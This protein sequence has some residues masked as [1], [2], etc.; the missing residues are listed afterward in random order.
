M[1]AFAALE[2]ERVGLLARVP[3]QFLRYVGVSVAALAA[4]TC[5]YLGLA[6]SGLPPV[7]AGA[8]GYLVGLAAHYIL[9]VALVFDA[10][11]SGKRQRRLV[12]EFVASGLFGLALTTCVISMATGLGLA[13]LAAKVVAVALSFAA[14]YMLRRSV[15]FAAR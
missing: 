4:D 15:V 6:W 2:A 7:A 3:V 10:E 11:A 9:S 13:L 12:A 8:A 5:V 1:A 14:V